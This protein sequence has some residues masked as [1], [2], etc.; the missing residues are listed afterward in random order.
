MIQDKEKRRAYQREYM[1]KRR[2]DPIE[3]AKG[4]AYHREYQKR[5]DVAEKRRA[6]VRERVKDPNVRAVQ[7]KY[8]QENMREYYRAYWHTEK[9]QDIKLRQLYGITLDQ[10]KEI[11]E[12]Q[13]NLCAI[14]NGPFK[15]VYTDHDHS[16]GKVRGLL[17]NGCNMRLSGLDDAE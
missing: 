5:P 7:T 2:E 13:N 4:N 8:K 12:K 3:R 16:T 14:C 11:L 17:C 15:K 9:G 6:Y 1:R 10:K